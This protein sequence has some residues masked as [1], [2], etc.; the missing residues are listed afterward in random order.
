MPRGLLQQRRVD[1]REQLT[2][3][4]YAVWPA[5][6]S[7]EVIAALRAPMDRAAARFERL[8]T[9]E[10]KDLGEGLS[11]TR[12]GL[13]M[14]RLLHAHP[15]LSDLALPHAVMSTI[16][17]VLEGARAELIGAVASDEHRPFFGWHTH[18]GG[19]DEGSRLRAN[20]WPVV[21][22]IER[23]LTLAY[24]DPVDAAS[25]ALL[26]MPRAA[27][28]DTAPPFDIQDESWPG[29]VE[30]TGPAGTIVALDQCTWHAVRARTVP[31]RRVFVGGYFAR[32]D[33]MPVAWRDESL[34]H[35][36]LG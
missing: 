21:T 10:A 1:R 19:E 24:L 32:A 17:A 4:G 12:T 18:I 34:A 36:R 5:L 35:L 14:P 30:I 25:G 29:A 6:L 27:G 7:A 13:A 28:D 11:L 23:V 15:E 2:G 16:D 20:A 8:H 9:D 26:V 22:R 33:A 3:R 31:G